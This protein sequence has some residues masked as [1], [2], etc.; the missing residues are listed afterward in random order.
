[1]MEFVEF[2]SIESH[3]RRNFRDARASF[4]SNCEASGAG[5]P[6]RRCSI[7]PMA[8]KDASPLYDSDSEPDLRRN[9][10]W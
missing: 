3:R 2:D 4:Q 9:A 1:M 10:S 8:V 5:V 7:A 6:V